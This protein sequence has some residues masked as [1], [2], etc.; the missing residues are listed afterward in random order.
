[1]VTDMTTGAPA[2]QLLLFAVPLMIGNLFQ[3]LYNLVDS[4]IVGRCIGSDALAAVGAAGSVTNLMYTL[5]MGFSIGAGIV[6]AQ[7]FGKKDKENL[8]EIIFAFYEN[9]F[10][11]TVIVS[12][13]GAAFAEKIMKVMQVPSNV[14]IQAVIYLRICCGGL[15]A[16]SFY[17][18]ASTILR[19]IGDAKTPLIS[20]IISALINIVLNLL[21][22]LK[23]QMGVAGVAYGTVLAQCASTFICTGR[24]I[25]N[26]MQLGLTAKKFMWSKVAFGKILRAALPSAIQYS[27][28]SFGGMSVQS[29]VNLFGT[30]TMAAYAAVQKIDMLAIQAIASM[31]NALSVFIG[32]N[33]PEKNESRMKDALQKTLMIMIAIGTLLMLGI[34]FFNRPLLTMFL[35]PKIAVL[36]I[37]IGSTY[38]KIMGIA[39]MIAGI[40]NS[41]LNFIRGAGDMNASLVAGVIEILSRIIFAYFSVGLIGVIGIWIA[42]PFSWGCACIYSIYRY[43]TGKWKEK[44][45]V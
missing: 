28:I 31:G 15:I 35:D 45:F 30:A 41:Y 22:V 2:K 19:N 36:E 18:V 24:L 9:V 14:M 39:Y 29:L 44:S 4:V 38:L 20:I 1:M 32:Q 21:F 7:Y 25:K 5:F 33:I 27:L 12:V 34:T 43:W 11:I 40:M 16:T 8:C 26:R 6:I 17:N 42:T 3:Q 13:F 10:I 23:F 37:K